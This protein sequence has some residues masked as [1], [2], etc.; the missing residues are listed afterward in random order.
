MLSYP[1]LSVLLLGMVPIAFL[2]YGK[3]VGD[4]SIHV[5]PPLLLGGGGTADTFFNGKR[6]LSASGVLIVERE[7]GQRVYAYSAAIPRP[8][9]SLTKLMTALLVV[10][11]HALDEVVTVPVG[12]KDVSGNTIGLNE[13]DRYLLGDIL[14][15]LLIASA[16]DAAFTLAVYHSGSVSE[17]VV[18]MNERA[19]I[20]GLKGTSF[21]NPT[22]FDAQE[23]YSTPQDLAWL[24]V[25]ALRFPT[26]AQRLS[27]RGARIRSL[28]GDV[29]SLTHT[30]AFLHADTPVKA[31]KTGTTGEAGQCL[32]SVVEWGGREYIVILLHSSDRYAD[33]RFIL[34][35]FERMAL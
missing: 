15:A 17:F 6:M 13:G 19:R 20:L 33:M 8:M 32:L 29:I 18:A 2:P 31:G 3:E 30:H 22:G 4:V 23:H 26:I 34:T 10:E 16:N 35:A 9:A 1:F 5:A 25:F 12:A 14:S 21:T 27:T 11:F 24:T 7:S 28:S